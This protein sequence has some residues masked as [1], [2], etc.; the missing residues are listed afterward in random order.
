MFWEVG[1]KALS[2]NVP[3]S[4]DDVLA[5]SEVQNPGLVIGND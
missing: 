1:N 3:A 4:E 2:G 5:R